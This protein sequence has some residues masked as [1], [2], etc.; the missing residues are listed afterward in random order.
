MRA[1]DRQD[2]PMLE[3]LVDRRPSMPSVGRAPAR[4]KRWRRRQARR[5]ARRALREATAQLRGPVA[6][7]SI[8]GGVS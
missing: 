7:R 1:L 4:V 8:A 2:D 3:A 6:D 5:N